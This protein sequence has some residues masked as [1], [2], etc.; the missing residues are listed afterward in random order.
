MSKVDK[1]YKGYDPLN[2][3]QIRFLDIYITNRFNASDAYQEVYECKNKKDASVGAWR[4]LGSPYAQDYIKEERKK[5]QISMNIDKEWLVQ[6]YIKVMDSC[7]KNGADGA[8]T[9]T[10]R[11]NWNKALSQLSKLLGLDS[12][13]EIDIT[14][15]KYRA[16]FGD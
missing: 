13:E 11:N 8:G 6:Q 5:F 4:V 1:K 9:I 3:R 2:E 16:K 15:R 14:I 10:D 12:P 7:E